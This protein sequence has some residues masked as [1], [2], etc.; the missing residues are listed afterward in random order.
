[1]MI[2]LETQLLIKINFRFQN[3]QN[4]GFTALKNCL[5]SNSLIIS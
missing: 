2:I 1:M 4:F 3:I 5:I